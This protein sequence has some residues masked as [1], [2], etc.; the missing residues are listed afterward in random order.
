VKTAKETLMNEIRSAAYFQFV[1]AIIALVVGLV[2]GGVGMWPFIVVA[3]GMA[4]GG[5]LTYMSAS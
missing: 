3:I 2:S 1:F 4:V 5:A